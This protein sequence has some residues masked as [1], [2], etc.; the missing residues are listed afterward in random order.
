[1]TSTAHDA[2]CRV[3]RVATLLAFV[4]IGCGPRSSS[5]GTDDGTLPN[6]ARHAVTN[7]PAAAPDPAAA[8]ELAATPKPAAVPDPIP[9]V[10]IDPARLPPGAVAQIG[11][12]RFELGEGLRSLSE[13]ADGSVFGHG[14]EYVRIWDGATG[15]TRWRMQTQSPG[16]LAAS[17]LDA[18]RIVTSE[19]HTVSVINTR[20]G[21]RL[22]NK[23]SFNTVFAV[24][25]S[26]NGRHVL[27]MTNTLARHDLATG[28][29]S[30]PPTRVRATA[31][32][33]RDDRSVIAV[34]RDRVVR[35]D[36]THQGAVET[37]A[38]L[39]V[40][41]RVIAFDASGTRVAWAL[42]D[43]FGL[44]DLGS[45][46]VLMDVKKTDMEFATLAVSADGRRV[47]TGTAGRIL[48]WEA[49]KDS[50]S[51]EHPVPYKQKPP[52]AF[53]ASGE[54]I[55]RAASRMM[56]LSPDGQLGPQ[57]AVVRFK[58]FAADGT[59]VLDNDGKPTGFDIAH[60]REAPAGAVQ[61]DPI[62]KDAPGW[63]D[64][65]VAASDGSITAWS[66]TE[67]IV[68]CGKI[69]VWRSKGG[70]WTSGKPRTCEAEGVGYPWIA[71]P[72]M[73]ADVSEDSPVV[74]DTATGKRVL[75]IPADGRKLAHLRGAP[76]QELVVVAF[77]QP[78]YVDRDDPHAG[79]QLATGYY[80]ELWSR[81]SGKQLAV[82]RAPAE[83]IGVV[84]MVASRDG[85]TV[86]IGWKDGT[87]DAL[88]LRPAKLR[89]LGR[90]PSGVRS[91]E[92]SPIGRMV[93]TVD[94]DGRAFIW[95]SQDNAA[96]ER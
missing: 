22:L 65:A 64:R 82:V 1:M 27:V 26:P 52:V 32:L 83:R 73:L 54:V 49:G 76:D 63:V 29:E 17:A 68:E 66:E 59:L 75:E 47:A 45:G 72:G 91:V 51:W 62:P 80:L 18:D 10:I 55:F 57:P 7:E 42:G 58:G 36:G 3:G 2:A 6:P 37:A 24:A 8:P 44:V 67:A 39:P 15:L 12:P 14:Y 81:K 5:P 23:T 19:A 70:L 48:V 20:T 89:T 13:H 92:E 88:E 86:Y 90:H 21:E 33:V 77:F 43:R 38:T 69:R 85:S 35:W 61:G 84:D 96:R 79:L 71:G 40:R 74:W 31:G 11:Q 94:D 50:P 95:L 30:W 46:T 78:D 87:V 56:R 34:E 53:V 9:D 93:A 25:I 60:E 28:E 16:L 4:L 41:P